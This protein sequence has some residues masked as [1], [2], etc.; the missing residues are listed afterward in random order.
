MVLSNYQIIQDVVVEL[1][2]HK[3]SKLCNYSSANLLGSLK[4]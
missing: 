2:R 4:G 3:Q 1:A